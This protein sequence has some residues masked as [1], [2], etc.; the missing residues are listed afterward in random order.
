[1]GW[2]S[3]KTIDIYDHTRDGEA[4]LSVLANYQH[5][6]SQRNYGQEPTP[7]PVPPNI[8]EHSVSP[9]DQ[10]SSIEDAG[11]IIWLHDAETLAWIKKQQAKQ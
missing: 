7:F 10:P 11:E 6:L 9:Q 4:V 5:D 8:Q 3:S 2:R 1:M